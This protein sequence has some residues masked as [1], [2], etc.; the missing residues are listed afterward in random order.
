MQVLIQGLPK[1]VVEAAFLP[2]GRKNATRV[3]RLILNTVLLVCV[4]I[5]WT[6]EMAFV[7]GGTGIHCNG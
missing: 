5:V 6:T 2:A 4:V 1:Q 7:D 3:L